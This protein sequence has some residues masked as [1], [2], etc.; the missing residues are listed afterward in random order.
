MIGV[1]V[2]IPCFNAERWISKALQSAV[3]QG[4]DNIEIIVID[5]GSTDASVKIIEKEFP[6]VNLVKTMHQG[7]SRARNV[8]T[9]LAKGE[10]IQYLDA[11]DMLLPDKIKIQIGALNKSGADVAYGDWK[12]IIY[13]SDGSFKF[14]R[15]H[16]YEMKAPFDITLFTGYWSP[17]SSYL[18]RRAIIEKVGSCPGLRFAGR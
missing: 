5:D 4:G 16:D 11:D 17:I 6:R 12:E 15:F 9:A 1:S 7:A 2:I 13:L 14:G 3:I 18:F 8:G 10:F